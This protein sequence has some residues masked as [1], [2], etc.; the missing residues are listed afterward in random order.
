MNEDP[1]AILWYEIAGA[2]I[3]GAALLLEWW[4]GIYEGL[5][6]SVETHPRAWSIVRYAGIVFLFILLGIA[7]GN[8]IR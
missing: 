7:V 1:W 8:A 6:R 5:A 3:G 2:V 4:I